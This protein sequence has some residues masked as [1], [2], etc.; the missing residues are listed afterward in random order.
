MHYT[1]YTYVKYV[2]ESSI[3]SENMRHLV[4]I[5]LYTVNYGYHLYY[6]KSR[7]C[8]KTG[9]GDHI[10]IIHSCYSRCSKIFVISL[11][12][13]SGIL[14]AIACVRTVFE[15]CL[16]TLS[17]DNNLSTTSCIPRLLHAYINAEKPSLL[18]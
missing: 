11:I 17:I 2:T 16:R 4:Y 9:V 15:T 8:I 10:T 3:Y 1:F 6:K 12:I 5:N 13:S 18:I 7:S 14:H